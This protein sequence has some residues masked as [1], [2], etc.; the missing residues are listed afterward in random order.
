ML[1]GQQW[2]RSERRKQRP[3]RQRKRRS[4]GRR[5]SRRRCRSSATLYV[6]DRVTRAG[7][8][9]GRLCALPDD[10]PRRAGS[11]ERQRAS[12]GR[13]SSFVFGRQAQASRG[14][15]RSRWPVYP[16]LALVK[17]K[18]ADLIL[19]PRRRPRC[20]VTALPKIRPL[21]ASGRNP[22]RRFS[23]PAYSLASFLSALILFAAR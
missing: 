6:G 8:R 13:S 17:R 9:R 1:G 3:R 10:L 18:P 22:R 23:L 5:S 21:A 2:R 16:G 11:G 4:V 19:G 15:K 12:A 7:S 20:F 14:G